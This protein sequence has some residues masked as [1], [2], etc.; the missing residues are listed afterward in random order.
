MQKINFVT[1]LAFEILMLKNP[2]IWLAD[3]IF[4][5]NHTHLKLHD[6]FVAFIDMKLHA[7]NQLYNSISFWDI[8]ALKASLGMPQHAWSKPPKLT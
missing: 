3:S 7:Q 4:A 5:F 8:K 6:K 1:P 2:A